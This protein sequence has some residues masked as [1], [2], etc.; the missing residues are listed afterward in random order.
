M[1]EE[2]F[3]KLMIDGVVRNIPSHIK[4][5]L[6]DMLKNARRDGTIES[7]QIGNMFV[8]K[9]FGIVASIN[10]SSIISYLTKENME[11]FCSAC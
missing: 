6:T 3:D 2:Y 8:S 5:S 9:E 1:V 11:L 4:E 10:N 7:Y